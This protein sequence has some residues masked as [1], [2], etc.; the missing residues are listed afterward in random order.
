M[1]RSQAIAEINAVLAS[2]DDERLRTVADIVGE[3]A[4][5]GGLPRDLTSRE[6]DMVARSRADFAAGDTMTPDEL[7]RYLDAAAAKR[8]AARGR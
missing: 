6:L 2:L 4:S 7:D 5:D 1:S 3:I 8:A